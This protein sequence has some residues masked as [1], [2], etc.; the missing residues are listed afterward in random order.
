MDSPPP[1][2]KGALPD[3]AACDQC[4]AP[5]TLK[6]GHHFLCDACY[7]AAGS[8]CAEGNEPIEADG[9]RNHSD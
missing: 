1:A 9:P 3:S 2:P 5:A 6:I 8:C 4:G 7:A